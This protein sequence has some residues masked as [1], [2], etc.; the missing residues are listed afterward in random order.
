MSVAPPS[1]QEDGQHT[2]FAPFGGSLE[3]RLLSSNSF[4]VRRFFVREEDY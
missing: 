4:C 1:G 3:R 2:G